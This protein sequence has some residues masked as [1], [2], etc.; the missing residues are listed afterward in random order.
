MIIIIGVS[1]SLFLYVPYI[2]EHCF[3]LWIYIVCAY[4]Y[5]TFPKIGKCVWTWNTHFVD[6]RIRLMQCLCNCINSAMQRSPYIYIY[7]YIS[8]QFATCQCTLCV[9]V[10]RVDVQGE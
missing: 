6:E 7:I 8:I 2:I 9:T 1:Y 3:I 10:L 5:V 4:N